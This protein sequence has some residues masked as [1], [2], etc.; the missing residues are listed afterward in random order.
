M[1]LFFK[2]FFLR[3]IFSFLLFS[4]ILGID[5]IFEGKAVK[6]LQDIYFLYLQLIL[7]LSSISFTSEKQ[8]FQVI[9]QNNFKLV[10]TYNCTAIWFYIL[11]TAF[12]VSLPISLRKKIFYSVLSFLVITVFNL[13]RIFVMS[14]IAYRVPNYFDVFHFVL[15]Q[16]IFI[17]L[18]L[19]IHYYILK[20]SLKLL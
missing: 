9:L 16:G 19:I 1:L 5:A 12:V 17:I 2:N 4:S 20:R 13:L 15:F 3:F 6:L 18:F 7:R 14:I 11:S 10:I 8:N